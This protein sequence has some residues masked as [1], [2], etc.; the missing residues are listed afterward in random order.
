M[1]LEMLKEMEEKAMMSLYKALITD[2]KVCTVQGM[3]D[4][5][6]AIGQYR[7]SHYDNH[8]VPVGGPDVL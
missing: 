7:N 2:N 1:T 6:S 8:D 3:C 5:L 4:I